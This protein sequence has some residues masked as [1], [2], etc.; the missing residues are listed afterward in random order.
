MQED[1]VERT[2]LFD[3][4]FR[5]AAV[6]IVHALLLRQ[7][8]V[9]ARR[10]QLSPGHFNIGRGP[11]N[12]LTLA[13]SEVSRQ[14]CR[15]DIARDVAVLV[16][17]ASTNGVYLD[18]QQ[19]EGQAI[20]QSG[21]R[22]SVG[23][24]SLIYQRGTAEELA[25]AEA[26]ERELAQAV[27]Y[28]RAL[29]PP[30]LR[31]GPVRA[32]WHFVP[33]ALLGGDV[34]GYRWL[35]EQH[36]SIFLLDVCGH[37][38]SSALLAASAA[39]MLRLPGPGLDLR[40]PGAVL[41]GMNA[42]FQMEEHNGLFFT[43]WYGVYEPITRELRFA[44]AGHH[45]AYLVH[46]TTWQALV[47]DA[48]TVGLSPVGCFEVSQTYVPA[49]AQLHLFSDGAFEVT[50]PDG[51]LVGVDKLLAL[52]KRPSG[53]KREPEQVYNDLRQLTGFRPFEDD[54]SLMSLEFI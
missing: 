5:Q 22:L 38:V 28:I 35:D 40:D 37:G 54:F 33:S 20:L 7:D 41:D 14:H 13:S 9:P 29:L 10:I 2:T 39:N 34:F 44:S 3:R 11:L 30:P 19:I 47:T 18:G 51:T 46:D 16:D 53:A 15:I 24:F 50:Y 25:E 21:A 12:E 27:G 36:L 31:S 32:E 48:P 45:P 49:G 43:I 1:E 42:A 26:G 52:L 6:A 23:Q 8:G 17:L 4:P